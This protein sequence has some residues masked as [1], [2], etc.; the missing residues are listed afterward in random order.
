VDHRLR[1][2]ERELASLRKEVGAL[3]QW[4]MDAS[5]ALE[6]ANIKI[7]LSEPDDSWVEAVEV[8]VS[9][10]KIGDVVERRAVDPLN[11]TPSFLKSEVE[12]ECEGR[13]LAGAY[14]WPCNVIDVDPE[15]CAIRL[16][17]WGY[18]ESWDHWV[19]QRDLEMGVRK[20]CFVPSEIGELAP[21]DRVEVQIYQNTH[22]SD[23]NSDQAYCWCPGA[24]LTS[25][26]KF[27]SVKLDA[28]GLNQIKVAVSM[29]RRV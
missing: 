26:G 10:Y 19:A 16:H 2:L 24:I 7:E 4:K 21:K 23:P 14:W 9:G 13:Y 18:D 25:D 27:A 8:S 3:R 22:I 11:F 6:A 29:L 5:K 17:Y 20:Q 15:T 1:K 12:F 28:E